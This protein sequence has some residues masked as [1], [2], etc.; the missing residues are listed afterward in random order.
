MAYKW[1]G[2]ALAV[3]LCAACGTPEVQGLRRIVMHDDA[4]NDSE[5]AEDNGF[6]LFGIH[7]PGGWVRKPIVLQI[8]VDTPPDAREGI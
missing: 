8:P 6:G 5:A 7:S 1:L 2:A 3:S 4:A